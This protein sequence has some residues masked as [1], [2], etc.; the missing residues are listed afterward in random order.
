MNYQE[1]HIEGTYQKYLTIS[2]YIKKSNKEINTLLDIGCN[3]GKLLDYFDFDKELNIKTFGIEQNNQYVKD[4]IKIIDLNIN[5]INFIK[6]HDAVLLLSVFH[7]F[8]NDED[9]S[10]KLLKKIRRKA[11]GIFFFQN[12]SIVNKFKFKVYFKNN[13]K[14]SIIDYNMNFLKKV[15]PEDQI[16]YIGKSELNNKNEKY[17]YIFAVQKG[18]NKND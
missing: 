11:K 17:R 6:K 5:N 18:A 14:S 16:N 9:Y 13:D 2:K 8:S 4:N 15:F 7:Q 12:P 3:S 1:T 10:I